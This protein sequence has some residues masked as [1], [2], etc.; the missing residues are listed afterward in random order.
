MPEQLPKQFE[1]FKEHHADL[2]AAYENLGRQCV[3]A[4]KLDAKTQRLV[5]LALA[6]AIGSQGA[7]H[8]HVRQALA[9][10]VPK[11][12]LRHVA[13]LAIPTIGFPRSMAAMSW[14]NDILK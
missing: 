14:I 13:L 2:F 1:Q 8:S 10:G 5:K 3:K 11:D 4:G 6:I 12:E 9:E 7:V